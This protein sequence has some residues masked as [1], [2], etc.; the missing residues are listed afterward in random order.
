VCEE[1]VRWVEYEARD[2]A[3]VSLLTGHCV[4]L[5]RTRPSGRV[6]DE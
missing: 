6:R 2:S 5:A 1:S 3:S 4:S